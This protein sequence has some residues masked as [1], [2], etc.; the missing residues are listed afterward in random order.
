MIIPRNYL[1]IKK[2]LKYLGDIKMNKFTKKQIFFASSIIIVSLPLYGMM[3]TIKEKLYKTI[4]KPMIYNAGVYTIDTT[5]KLISSTIIR[6][7]R[8]RHKKETDIQKKNSFQHYNQK[9]DYRLAQ[10]EERLKEDEKNAI[11]AM[12]REFNITTQ[13]QQTINSV[14]SQYKCFQKQYLSQFHKKECD[15]LEFVSP[16]ILS[17]CK[18]INI[19][20]T[21]VEL[22]IS[23][24][25]SPLVAA[26]TGLK[27]NYQFENDM[28]VVDDNN[29]IAY[30]A[31][32]LY[33]N[34]FELSYEQGIATIGHELTHLA[35]QHE[36]MQNI[37]GMEIKYFTEAKREEI[38]NSKNWKKIETIY[39]RQAE[40]LHKDAEWA[41]RMRKKRNSSYYD[42]QL[43]LKHYAQ[44]TEIDELHKLKEKINA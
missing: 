5:A 37:L 19:N 12:Y 26:A 35:L 29:I 13:D 18:Q 38:M 36:E 15:T 23:H 8:I 16:E 11:N 44:L 1:M 31:I 22:K 40:I 9:I 2:S 42:N 14:L 39:E 32:I 4:E 10:I 24:S 7:V 17:F 27:A 41:S 25:S 43:F 34:F 21:A 20:P 30:P 3:D 6:L 28:L 33:P